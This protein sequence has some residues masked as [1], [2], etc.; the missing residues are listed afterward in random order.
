MTDWSQSHCGVILS[1]MDQTLA[2]MPEASRVLH[3]LKPIEDPWW[4]EHLIDIK[5][6]MLM[7]GMWPCIPNWHRDFLKRD[8]DGKRSGGGLSARSMYS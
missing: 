3:Q 6:H 4:E 2:L 1:T 7:P 5:V 8:K